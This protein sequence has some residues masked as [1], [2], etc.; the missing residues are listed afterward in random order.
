MLPRDRIDDDRFE[1]FSAEEG[2]VLY[3]F[4]HGPCGDGNSV[5]V[6]SRGDG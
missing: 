6:E 4:Y 5:Q 2:R 3:Q 1:D